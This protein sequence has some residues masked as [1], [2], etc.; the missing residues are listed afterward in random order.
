MWSLAYDP[1]MSF[2]SAAE[3]AAR[4]KAEQETAAERRRE[5]ARSV[6]AQAPWRGVLL[7]LIKK[8]RLEP[9]PI[10]TFA[11]RRFNEATRHASVRYEAAGS[12]WGLRLTRDYYKHDA[13]TLTL[14]V[15]HTA[16]WLA[17]QFRQNE[18][19]HQVLRAASVLGAYTGGTEQVRGF[20]PVGGWSVWMQDQAGIHLEDDALLITALLINGDFAGPDTEGI[21]LFNES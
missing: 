10:F 4:L 13:R 19:R 20:P 12:A 8:N 14:F 1:A 2:E 21:Y 15:N 5:S 3:L 16:Y 18:R 6:R 7:D 11:D 17:S 9:V